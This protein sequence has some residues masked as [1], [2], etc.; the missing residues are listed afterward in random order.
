MIRMLSIAAAATLAAAPL[1]A[2]SGPYYVATP[3]AAPTKT[4]L[5]TRSTLWK[6]SNNAYVAPRGTDRDAILCELLAR[7]TGKLAA[8]SAGGK[9][10]DDAAL[11]K[12]NARAK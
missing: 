6:L 7:E 5:V 3:A 1:A 12:C 4:S 2:Q 8:F 11:T 9:A 10:F